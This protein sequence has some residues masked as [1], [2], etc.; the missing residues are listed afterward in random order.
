MPKENTSKQIYVRIPE[1][2]QNYKIKIIFLFC[3]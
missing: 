2:A 3:L 1:Y